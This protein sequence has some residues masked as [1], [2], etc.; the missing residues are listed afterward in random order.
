MFGSAAI[1]L[2]F[3]HLYGVAD[4]SWAYILFLFMAQGS[5]SL[6]SYSVR[7]YNQTSIMS[8][9]D[10]LALDNRNLYNLVKN[11]K[12]KTGILEVFGDD[13]QDA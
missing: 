6:F 13:K 1:V 3:M 5:T 8:K 7:R 2:L 10:A 4:I 9:L 12:K 11:E